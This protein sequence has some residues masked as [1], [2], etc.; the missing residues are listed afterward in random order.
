[1]GRGKKSFGMPLVKSIGIEDESALHRR[2]ADDDGRNSLVC[3]WTGLFCVHLNSPNLLVLVVK[4]SLLFS[5][6]LCH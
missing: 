3:V 6:F 2:A 1:M 5:L 4:L